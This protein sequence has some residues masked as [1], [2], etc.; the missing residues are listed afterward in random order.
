MV[1]AFFLVM[2]DVDLVLMRDVDLDIDRWRLTIVR[3]TLMLVISKVQ[4]VFKCMSRF[5]RQ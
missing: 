4:N 3:A 2:P 5:V 1:A